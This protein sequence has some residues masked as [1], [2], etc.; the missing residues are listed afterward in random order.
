MIR[1][2]MRGIIELIRKHPKIRRILRCESPYFH[3][4]YLGVYLESSVKFKCSF[5]KN[6]AGFYKAFNIFGKIGR[7][8][9]EEVLFALV[10]SKCLPILS[11]GT[12]A[13][14]IISADKHSLEFTM[15]IV[16]YKIFG[17]MSKDSYGEICKYFGID[18]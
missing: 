3:L 12:E 18:I 4:W 2:E 7:N 16:L 10:K 14:P 15:N 11:Y 8:T 17:P 6:K 13:C 9:S 5:A 1:T